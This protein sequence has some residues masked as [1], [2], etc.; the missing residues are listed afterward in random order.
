MVVIL[1]AVSW[2]LKKTP[3]PDISYIFLSNF[4]AKHILI[5]D[6]IRER[7]MWFVYWMQAYLL[8]YTLNLPEKSEAQGHSFLLALSL[9]S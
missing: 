3:G 1:T 9:A 7:E 6:A 5:L 2:Y 4:R 8:S